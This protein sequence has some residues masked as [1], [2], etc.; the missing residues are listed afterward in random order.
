MAVLDDDQKKAL[1]LIKSSFINGNPP[2]TLLFGPPGSGKSFVLVDVA[3][4]ALKNK[5]GVVV[6]APT[7]RAVASIKDNLPPA[8]ASLPC[9]TIHKV[10]DMIKW[11]QRD[12]LPRFMFEPVG[13][14]L[15][16]D[17]VGMLST[18]L[19]WSLV[20]HKLGNRENIKIVFSG[21]CN[22]LPPASGKPFYASEQFQEDLDR[23]A[24][25]YAP[26]TGNHRNGECARL[27]LLLE[28]FKTWRLTQKVYDL[29]DTIARKKIPS[30]VWLY[31][32]QR[33][34]S[35]HRFN[36]R[37]T[38][39][40]AR[41][42]P[43]LTKVFLRPAE[44]RDRLCMVTPSW[45]DS[46][47]GQN[48][49][50]TRIVIKKNIYD[51]NECVAANGDFGTVLKVLCT[52]DK[53]GHVKFTHKQPEALLVR[54]DRSP[55]DEI[56]VN[57][58]AIKDSSTKKLVWVVDFALGYAGTIHTQQG[59]TI[60]APKKLVINV[61]D[62]SPEAMFV[63]LSRVQSIDQLYFDCFDNSPGALE[64]VFKRPEEAKEKTHFYRQLPMLNKR[65]ETFAL[66]NQSRKNK[67]ATLR[68]RKRSCLGF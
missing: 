4:W 5:Y 27:Q 1:A 51:N 60:P 54:L 66:S 10:L 3:L 65:A 61:T 55:D 39:E 24:I 23:G 18:E 20:Y 45:Y 47:I 42:N 52:P 50:G 30:F 56:T 48:R 6:C 34:E 14:L 29:L 44:Y 22:Q 2:Q 38:T 53:K 19:L 15:I 31:I 28:P 62:I 21:D 59:R 13:G 35:L 63:A 46:S 17:E 8:L 68:K 36:D 32:A 7:A 64:K 58:R 16:I 67:A 25:Q 12:I 49:E 33:H 40:N 41:L 26:L 11:N 57:A 37:R 9:F 43:A